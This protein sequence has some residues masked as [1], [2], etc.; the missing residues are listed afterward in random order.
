MVEDTAAGAE[1][2]RMFSRLIEVERVHQED[3]ERAIAA[4]P[5][6]LEVLAGFLD[7]NRLDKL[8]AELTLTSWRRKGVKV[9]GRLRA[10]TEQTC[11]VT[12]EPMECRY[13]DTFERTFLPAETLSK[14]TRLEDVVDAEGDDPPDPIEHGVIDV[15]AVVLEQFALIIDYYPRR[16]GAEI[17]SR[18]GEATEADDAPPNPFAQLQALKSR[19]SGDGS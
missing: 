15:G 4:T 7:L 3:I 17:D 6:E 9:T 19:G 13:D 12:L 1:D 16:E 10:V 11:V 14:Q 5:E 2:D 8:E 18:Y